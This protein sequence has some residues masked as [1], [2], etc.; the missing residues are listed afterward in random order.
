MMTPMSL[1]DK[2]TPPRNKE[3]KSMAKPKG[4]VKKDGGYKVYLDTYGKR[5]Y[6]GF[7]KE[8]EHAKKALEDVKLKTD[9]T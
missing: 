3:R 9:D 6:I 1:T 8:I 5:V 2:Y 4:I 7:Y